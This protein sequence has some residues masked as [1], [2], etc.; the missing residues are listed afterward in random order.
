MALLCRGSADGYWTS[1]GKLAGARTSM[2]RS[3]SIAQPQALL[4]NRDFMGMVPNELGRQ[5][6]SGPL[7]RERDHK[8]CT[9]RSGLGGSGCSRCAQEAVLSEHALA[10]LARDQLHE[11]ACRLGIV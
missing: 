3:A 2:V 1:R 6:P 7:A 9:G 5:H 11:L 10:L 8:G 4:G